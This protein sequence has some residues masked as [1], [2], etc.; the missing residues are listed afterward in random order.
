ME[1][2]T[3]VIPTHNE[4]QNLAPPVEG[5]IKLGPDSQI[6]VNGHITHRWHRAI[7]YVNDSLVLRPT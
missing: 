6:V 3:I 2:R 7:T 5:I 1:Q 4:R